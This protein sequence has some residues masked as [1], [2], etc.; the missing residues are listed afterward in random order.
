MNKTHFIMFHTGNA[1]DLLG[2][3]R[4]TIYRWIKS[5]KI[6]SDQSQISGKHLFTLQE[7]NRVRVEEG[8]RA[9]TEDEAIEIWRTRE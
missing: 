8:K 4:R 3:S 7:I 9:L 5:G 2:K 1:V 6:V